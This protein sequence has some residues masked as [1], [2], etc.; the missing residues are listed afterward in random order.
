M[1][2][3]EYKLIIKQFNSFSTFL[4]AGQEKTYC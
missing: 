4:T 3:Y 1:L 2:N